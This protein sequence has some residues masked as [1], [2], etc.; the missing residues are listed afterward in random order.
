MSPMRTIAIVSFALL[1]IPTR[2]SAAQSDALL[3]QLAFRGLVNDFAGVMGPEEPPLEA[4]LRE[5][6]QKTGAQV[7]VVTLSSLEGGEISD[8]S[9]RL[10]ERWGIG[11][12]GEDNGVLLLA[13]IEDR[14]V[15]IEVGYGLEPLI[16]DARAGRVLDEAV[17][18]SFRQE[19][20][21]PGLAAGAAS[22]ALLVANESGVELTGRLTPQPVATETPSPFAGLLRLLV[23]FV[24]VLLFIRNPWLAFM[25][26]S[27]G[28]MSGGF[29]GGGFGRGG[30]G[31][32]GG[33]G[34]GMS[35]GGG[36][37]RSW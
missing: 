8:F 20:Y 35:G 26:L 30:G 36:A 16:P 33:F 2:S 18:P 12:A 14:Q 5:L 23:L 24:V 19:Q 3:E 34:G 10:F 27:S 28:R 11:Q 1:L 31:G 32:F 7:A 9:N 17:L 13:A 21:G 25:L 15:W 22:L 6:E 4:L 37:G 29:G